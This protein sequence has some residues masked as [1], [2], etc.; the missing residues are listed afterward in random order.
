MPWARARHKRRL[1]KLIIA[2][3]GVNCWICG[4]PTLLQYSQRNSRKYASLDHVIPRSQG[5]TDNISNL[6]L[7]HQG[8]NNWRSNNEGK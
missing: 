5:G 2:R 4:A 3:D 1:R 6:R 8:C 7:A